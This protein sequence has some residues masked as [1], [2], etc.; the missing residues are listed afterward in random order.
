MLILGLIGAAYIFSG[1]LVNWLKETT[2]IAVEIRDGSTSDQLSEV[3]DFLE[4]DERILE[5][6]IVHLPPEEALKVLGMDVTGS[7]W[8]EDDKSPFRDMVIFNVKA[9]WFTPA[10][11]SKI[12]RNFKEKS[13][14]I[15]EIHYQDRLVLD[16]HS[17]LENLAWWFAGFGL[18]FLML[19][20]ILI[21][22]TTKL[23]LYADRREIETMEL[24]GA[25]RGFI[26]RPYLIKSF[27]LG[28]ISGVI[29]LGAIG[30]I[31]YL[32]YDNPLTVIQGSDL[33]NI[34]FLVGGLPL[35]AGIFSFLCTWLTLNQYL[36]PGR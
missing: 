24:V 20:I 33:E 27:F 9:D 30:G 16:F 17:N 2:D 31:I 11:L 1:E 22:N 15:E 14:L 32:A 13:S 28:T 3:M 10:E 12:R 26:R 8:W 23:A 4:A 7:D 34:I 35:G 25:S 18:L 19:S 5:G 21:Y 6:S 29:A 36:N